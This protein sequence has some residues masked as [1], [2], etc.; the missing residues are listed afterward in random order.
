MTSSHRGDPSLIDAED[1]SIPGPRERVALAHLA[2][3][4]SLTGEHRTLVRSLADLAWG[5]GT[6]L[7]V[8]PEHAP[9]LLVSRALMV[10]DEL[11]AGIAILGDF[12]LDAPEGP[13]RDVQLSAVGCRSWT[14][15][16]QGRVADAVAQ[17]EAAVAAG[18]AEASGD[19]V[20]LAAVIAACRT[21]RGRLDRAE[22]AL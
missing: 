15:F 7:E 18:A 5:D 16:H 11:E 20:S 3:A 4:R 14:L 19:G 8:G 1:L 21:A 17:A 2:L 6:P 10:V 12:R 9:E 22:T 13:R